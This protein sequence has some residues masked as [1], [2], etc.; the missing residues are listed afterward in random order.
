MGFTA[1]FVYKKNNTDST[2]FCENLLTK[3]KI[4]VIMH[5]NSTDSTPNG[6]FGLGNK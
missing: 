6:E 3:G 5:I 2:V 4:R 1:P